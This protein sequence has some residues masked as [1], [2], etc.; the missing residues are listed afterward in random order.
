MKNLILMTIGVAVLRQVANYFKIKS[1][2]DMVKLVKPFI[3]EAV[4]QTEKRFHLH[5]N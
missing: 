1:F 3:K 5:L 4:K 2:E